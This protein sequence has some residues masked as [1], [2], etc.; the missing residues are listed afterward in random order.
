MRL[1]ETSFTRARTFRKS[2][3]G[4]HHAELGSLVSV[5]VVNYNGMKIIRRCLDSVLRSSYKPLEVVVV[6]NAST[7]GS[8]QYLSRRYKK[9]GRI[10]LV[11]CDRNL[12][13][14]AGSNLGARRANGEY[15]FFLNCDTEA[16]PSAVGNLVSVLERHSSV[17]A[18]Q[19]KLLMMS[20]RRR[21]DSAGDFICTVGWPYSRGKRT[22]DRGQ[23]DSKREIFS[24]RG[25]AMFVRKRVF[26]E[27]DGFDADY[28]MYYEDVDL[29]WRIRLRGYSIEFAASSVV[30]HLAGGRFG[31]ASSRND[32]AELLL[33][34][35]L[36]RDTRKEFRNAKSPDVRHQPSYR[37]IGHNLV[38][39][40]QTTSSRSIRIH[41]CPSG[42]CKGFSPEL[43]E[44]SDRAEH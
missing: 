29:S 21:L 42:S 44:T 8:A 41:G 22:I 4:S 2:K 17:A 7:D 39:Y 26:D 35:K 10:V 24:A 5:I 19:S 33:W 43:E 1:N 37:P 40:F 16:M 13:F 30:Y 3:G 38:P 25:A 14:A 27:V 6:D 18:A 20:D 11:I 34:A 32:C 12:G 9:N 31:R 15:L 23:Y 28:F 36:Y